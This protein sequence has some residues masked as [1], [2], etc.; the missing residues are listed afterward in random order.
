MVTDAAAGVSSGRRGMGARRAQALPLV[1]AVA[2]LSWYS[3]ACVLAIDPPR[4]RW[5]RAIELYRQ[6]HQP[7]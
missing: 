5:N 2:L 7:I 1:Q 4:C 3:A 6:V